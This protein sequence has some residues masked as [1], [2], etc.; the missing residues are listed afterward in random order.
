MR[1]Q[2]LDARSCLKSRRLDFEQVNVQRGSFFV[3]VAHIL[4]DEKILSS[5]NERPSQHRIWESE[6]KQ[7][8]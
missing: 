7:A 4:P 6:L 3:T 8:T 1:W 2:C 5:L